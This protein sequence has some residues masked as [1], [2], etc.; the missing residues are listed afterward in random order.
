[1]LSAVF[2]FAVVFGGLTSGTTSTLSP[3][4]LAGGE[5][6]FFLFL[7]LFAVA[8][9]FN[10]VRGIA[11]WVRWIDGPRCPKC[12]QKRSLRPTGEVK[13]GGL[14]KSEKIEL[15]CKHCDFRLWRNHSSGDDASVHISSSGCGA[16]G[17][18]GCG[19]GGCGGGGCG[20]G[21]G[22]G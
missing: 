11:G 18:S 19:G 7:A 3:A 10:I 1:M 21:C 13:P 14:F 15:K 12:R 5:I 17:G 4:L 20:G 9:I 6:F 8:F 22:G 16:C 2:F